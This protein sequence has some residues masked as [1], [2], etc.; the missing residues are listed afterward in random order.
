[1]GEIP[2][3]IDDYALRIR[4]ESRQNCEPRSDDATAVEH[5]L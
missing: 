4:L 5:S 2:E 1:M 3:A